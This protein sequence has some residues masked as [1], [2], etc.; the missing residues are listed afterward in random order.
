MKLDLAAVASDR[1]GALLFRRL[2]AGAD[3]LIDDFAPNS[4]FQSLV[5][6]TWLK[7]INPRLVSCSITAFGKRGP[8]KDEPPIDDLVLARMGVLS[9][10]PGFRPA[11]VHVVHPLPTVGGALLICLAVASSLLA[12][13]TTGRGRA[14]ETTLMAGALLYHP[15]VLG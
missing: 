9:G 1:D 13:E 3:V 11:P 6:G 10:M 15:K 5:D 8:L 4:P 14:S 2:I 7:T 12:R